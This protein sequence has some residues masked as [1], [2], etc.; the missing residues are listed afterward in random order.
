[1]ELASAIGRE[2]WEIPAY[3]ACLQTAIGAVSMVD[4]SQLLSRCFIDAL[5][6]GSSIGDAGFRA[7]LL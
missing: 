1:M 4:S 3:V 2:A 5:Y 6:L 7:R